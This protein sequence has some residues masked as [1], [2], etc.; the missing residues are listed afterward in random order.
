[1]PDLFVADVDDKVWEGATGPF[2]PEAQFDVEL[3]R[4][5][6]HLGRDHLTAAKFLDDLRD[7]PSLDAR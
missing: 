6:A 7:L 2:S 5:G 3:G 4:T 1:M